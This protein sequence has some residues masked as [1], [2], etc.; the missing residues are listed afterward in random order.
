MGTPALELPCSIKC[1]SSYFPARIVGRIRRNPLCKSLTIGPGA[2]L[3]SASLS[4]YYCY[5]QSFLTTLTATA[6][7]TQQVDLSLSVHFSTGPLLN[8][9]SA[10]WQK[11]KSQFLVFS[12]ISGSSSVLSW[13]LLPR[14]GGGLGCA[15]RKWL[16]HASI[17]AIYLV[18]SESCPEGPG[19]VTPHTGTHPPT[20]G[21]SLYC[22]HYHHVERGRRVLA[23]QELNA[24]II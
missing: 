24:L 3:Y 21:S 19:N 18:P 6:A 5:I 16:V 20:P 2:H 1:E 10:T 9:C 13:F 22:T 11:I 14:S 15:L 23:W 17:Q 12:V 8:P 7:H 4:L